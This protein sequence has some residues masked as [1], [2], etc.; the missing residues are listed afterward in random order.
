LTLLLVTPTLLL[1]NEQ[2]DRATRSETRVSAASETT[3]DSLTT[4]LLRS[5]LQV[6]ALTVRLVAA[7]VVVVVDVLAVVEDADVVVQAVHLL[8][9]P[10]SRPLP[11][12]LPL[13]RPRRPLPVM[14]MAMTCKRLDPV[15]VV[16]VPIV[17]VPLQEVLRVPP[18]RKRRKRRRRRPSTRPKSWTA[19]ASSSAATSATVA[20]VISVTSATSRTSPDRPLVTPSP[21]AVADRVVHVVN[22][23][24]AA[25]MVVLPSPRLSACA[26]AGPRT[27]HV[28]TKMNAA[29]ST[30]RMMP[31]QACSWVLN[32]NPLGNATSSVRTAFAI[33]ATSAD[34]L[35]PRVATLLAVTTTRETRRRSSRRLT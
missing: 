14:V 29:S 27:R 20:T 30:A 4:R 2:T 34:S 16:D 33:L 25:V 12:V 35:T 31:D 10:P 19:K 21:P 22:P 23:L 7:A 13:P 11:V 5:L 1:V 32:A 8:L 6:V 28:S 15:V 26:T 9:L 17:E 3:V 18:L 24:A